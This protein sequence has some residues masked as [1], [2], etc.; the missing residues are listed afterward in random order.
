MEALKGAAVSAA[1][2]EQVQNRLAELDGYIPTLAIIR[3]GEKPDDISYEKGAMKKMASFGLN[4]QSYTFPE[5]ISDAL[6]KEEF[7]K[8]NADKAIDGILMLRPLP[9]HICEKDIEKMIDPAKY[10]DVISPENIAKV[11]AGD[12]TGFAPCTAEAVIEVLKAYNIPMQGKR[13]TV[14]GRSMVVGKPLSMLFVKENAT[15]TICHTRTAD[16]KAECSRAEILVAAAGRARMLDGA[17]AG[18]DAVVIDVGINVDENGR[19][20]GDVDYES[21]EGIASMA[22]PVP[23]G[24]GAVTTAVLAKHLVQAAAR[25]RG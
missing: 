22:T 14:V 21:L 18:K 7:A 16:L 3:V 13:V 9:K 24:V 17:Y 25:A 10:L 23:G 4:V 12:S 11:F 6:F 19:L 1:I 20:C 2:K 5:D 8:I 15:V